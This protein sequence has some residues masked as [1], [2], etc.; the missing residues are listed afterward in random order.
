MS[1]KYILG[2]SRSFQ[3]CHVLENE[4]II[5]KTQRMDH[6]ATVSIFLPLTDFHSMSADPMIEKAAMARET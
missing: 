1:Y 5:K 6:A 4:Q 3:S 2:I